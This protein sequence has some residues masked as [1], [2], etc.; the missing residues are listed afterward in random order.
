MKTRNNKPAQKKM[1]TNRFDMA[2]LRL[3]QHLSPQQPAAALK[4]H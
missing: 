2:L 3:G 4:K 1:S